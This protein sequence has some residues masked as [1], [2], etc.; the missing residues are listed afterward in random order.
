M[1]SARVRR[2]SVFDESPEK[3]GAGAA[4]ALRRSTALELLS[5]YAVTENRANRATSQSNPDY[6][7]HR[8][9]WDQDRFHYV[10]GGVQNEIDR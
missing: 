1:L 9:C 5:V 3:R 6:R 7:N 10:H 4:A 2:V 8:V